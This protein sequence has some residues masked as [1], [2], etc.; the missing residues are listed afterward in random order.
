MTTE[1]QQRVLLRIKRKRTDDP[2]ERL[3]VH[4]HHQ[5]L[6]KKSKLEDALESLSLKPDPAAAATPE[7]ETAPVSVI[8]F[9]R[10]DTMASTTDDKMRQRLAKT[11]QKHHLDRSKKTAATTTL[12]SRSNLA[13]QRKDK[14]LERVAKGRGLNLVDVA[15]PTTTSPATTTTAS[16]PLAVNGAELKAKALKRVMNP[17]E[18]QIDEA[19]WTAFKRNDF[20]AFFRLQQQSATKTIDPL[21]FQRPADGGSLL[22]AAAMHNRTD[23]IEALLAIHSKHV[24]LCD[25]NGK[26]AASFAEDHGHVAAATALRA[27]EA[28]EDDKQYVY[29]VYSIDVS[30]TKQL[31]TRAPSE[32]ENVPVV[33]VSTSVEKWLMYE[34]QGDMDSAERELHFDASDS[35]KDDQHEDDVDSNDEGYVFNDYP[36]EESSDEDIN[37]AASDASD[38]WQAA[39]QRNDR[40]LKHSD[41]PWSA[42]HAHRDDYEADGDY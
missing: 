2:V 22:M 37:D 33:E 9:T 17:M 29:D 8:L 13:Q 31:P 15:L 4:S 25:Y 34:A 35:D 28:V 24:G 26:T 12:E 39:W 7:P 30:A 19:I 40:D 1:Q 38:E 20:S 5:V 18:R 41:D 6:L 10:I 32:L 36:D 3:V 16:A 23:V 27:C 21:L 14:R 42:A 11:M